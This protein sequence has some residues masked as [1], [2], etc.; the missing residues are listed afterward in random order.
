MKKFNIKK[1]ISDII[2]ALAI[3]LIF[4]ALCALTKVLQIICWPWQV[5]PIE[6][7]EYVYYSII[8]ATIYLALLMFFIYFI[9]ICLYKYS[10]LQKKYTLKDCCMVCFFVIITL[11]A[12]PF[13]LRNVTDYLYNRPQI[14][15][16][17]A[18]IT[19][20]YKTMYPWTS[21]ETATMS[22]RRSRHSIRYFLNITLKNGKKIE[23]DIT[24]MDKSPSAVLEQVIAYKL[25]VL[26]R[27]VKTEGAISNDKIT[28]EVA[29]H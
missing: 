29:A 4:P 20:R 26:S 22:S 28:A 14:T 15:L 17:S 11:G 3:V 24:D 6:G 16:S 27:L 7:E 1:T 12:I 8:S 5:L 23:I 19:D 2:T 13:C 10:K 18:G 9:P 25:K 21:I